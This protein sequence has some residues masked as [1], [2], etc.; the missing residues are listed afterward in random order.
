MD[1]SIFKLTAAYKADTYPQK[2]NLG[3][4]A[5]RDDDNQPWVLPVVRK[6]RTCTSISETPLKKILIHHE[7]SNKSSQATHRWIMNTSR[8]L[9]F[10]STPAQRRVY[11]SA[12]TRLRSRRT[13]YRGV[14][15]LFSLSLTVAVAVAALVVC[16]YMCVCICA[17]CI[18][19][20][21]A[22][23][24]WELEVVR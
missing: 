18:A 23:G 2:I 20:A 24:G 11:C 3:V 1:E 17:R 16:A 14:L 10:R 6:V 19:Q 12:Q 13:G 7:R 8:L 9:D 4:G 15:L 22:P 21:A 5:Y